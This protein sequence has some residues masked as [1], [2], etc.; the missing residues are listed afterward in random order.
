MEDEPHETKDCE[1]N[2]D[3]SHGEEHTRISELFPRLHHPP[4]LSG[5]SISLWQVILQRP[6]L[7]EDNTKVMQFIQRLPLPCRCL[8]SLLDSEIAA[9]TPSVKAQ[10][11][12][13][14]TSV[15][16]LDLESMQVRIFLVF[17]ACIRDS[18]LVGSETCSSSSVRR[19]LQT[20]C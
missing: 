12:T 9:D 16:L 18:A 2:K 19:S 20:C 8:E 13:S 4:S 3:A 14:E 10:Q 1:I 17:P 7:M 6:I 5:H 11:G 15:A